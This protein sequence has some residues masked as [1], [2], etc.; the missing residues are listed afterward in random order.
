MVAPWI[1]GTA[2]AAGVRGLGVAA[3]AAWKTMPAWGRYGAAL[4][5]G[6]ILKYGL[7]HPTFG[8]GGQ[9]QAPPPAG[10][11]MVPNPGMAPGMQGG[12]MTQGQFEQMYGKQ[13]WSMPWENQEGFY[14]Q[15]ARE[16]RQLQRDLANTYGDVAKYQASTYGDV[17]K[18][19]SDTQRYRAGLDY[20][21][22]DL[23]S[24]R[25][26][27]GLRDT[28][29]T[30]IRMADYDYQGLR[31]T[32]ATRLRMADLQTGRDLEGLKNTNQSRIRMAEIDANTRLNAVYD[33]NRRDVRIADYDRIARMHDSDRSVERARWG[34]SMDRISGFG[35]LMR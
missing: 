10:P 18:Y 19:Q 24:S 4:T 23:Q 33:T 35:R 2:G 16:S 1:A 12:M 31:D 26:L 34:G 32:N 11:A 30:R 17:A 6:E 28:N 15:Q 8:L 29:Q 20:N 7:I 21:L 14:Q 22:G 27:E 25:N 9:H 5:G 13:G 3:T